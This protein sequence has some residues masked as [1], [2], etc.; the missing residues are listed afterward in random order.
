[1]VHE[2][3]ELEINYWVQHVRAC[4]T[5]PAAATRARRRTRGFGIRSSLD[6]VSRVRDGLDAPAFQS[7][8]ELKISN[9][10]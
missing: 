8:T 2:S 5:Q 9:L 7:S 6:V 1:M 10:N 4:A 3:S